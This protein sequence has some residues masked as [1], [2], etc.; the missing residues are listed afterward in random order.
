MMSSGVDAEAKA[1]Q[2]INALKELKK[3]KLRAKVAQ[4]TASN[5]SIT[6][7]NKLVPLFDNF[8]LTPSRLSSALIP[9]EKSLP[10]T[11]N[12]TR[13]STL[14]GSIG[15]D[16]SVL[17]ADTQQP[18]DSH[19]IWAASPSPAAILP[20]VSVTP[21]PSS[22]VHQSIASISSTPPPSPSYAG[23]VDELAALKLLVIELKEVANNTSKQ[24]SNMIT[25]IAKVEQHQIT[26]PVRPTTSTNQ[27]IIA[28]RNKVCEFI[29]PKR[30]TPI[31][32]TVKPPP[33]PIRTS[34]SFASLSTRVEQS[35]PTD[36][37]TIVSP[38]NSWT[39]QRSQV[40]QH[41]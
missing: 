32:R 29:V 36:D 25:R 30:T 41:S 16:E 18:A 19:N 40:Q 33:A 22:S 6:E 31:S 38:P 23:I 1:T 35:L 12:P 26:A 13:L 28:V 20:T 14:M 3:H 21:S 39:Q 17:L 34:N 10:A 5:N 15:W 2:A 24:M 4:D 37:V 27:P 8:V 9:P 7:V 11:S